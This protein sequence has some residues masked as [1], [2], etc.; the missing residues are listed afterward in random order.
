MK[1]AVRRSDGDTDAGVSHFERVTARGLDAYT[2]A[3]D[4]RAH[5]PVAAGAPRT[6]STL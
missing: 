1:T 6:T 3:A 4:H 2:I 5:L